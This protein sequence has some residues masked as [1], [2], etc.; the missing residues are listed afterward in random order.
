M[1]EEKQTYSTEDTHMILNKLLPIDS[2]PRYLGECDL[3]AKS[4][5]KKDG[6]VIERY[7][8]GLANRMPEFIRTDGLYNP[9]LG[10]VSHVERLFV[11]WAANTNTT[12]KRQKTRPDIEYIAQLIGRSRIIVKAVWDVVGPAKG[13]EGFGF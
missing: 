2:H 8:W 7:V 3:L 9:S 6:N 10:A 1:N 12:D 11:R 5:N 13:R 4:L